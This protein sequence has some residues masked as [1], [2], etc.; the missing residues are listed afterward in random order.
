MQTAWYNTITDLV[1][2]DCI[3]RSLQKN[4]CLY[5]LPCVL[6]CIPESLGSL[7]KELR[8]AYDKEGTARNTTERTRA[9]SAYLAVLKVSRSLALLQTEDLVSSVLRW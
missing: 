5:W 6:K 8:D 4:A 2:I 3:N 9:F 7:L 1:C